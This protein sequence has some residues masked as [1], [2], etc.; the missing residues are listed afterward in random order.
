MACWAGL[1]YQL[2]EN[3]VDKI[4]KETQ[5]DLQNAETKRLLK[6]VQGSLWKIGTPTP[7]HTPPHREQQNA[8]LGKLSAKKNGSW[9]GGFHAIGRWVVVTTWKD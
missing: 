4:V 1:L 9:K 8:R 2:H 5:S 7:P 3:D 6:P